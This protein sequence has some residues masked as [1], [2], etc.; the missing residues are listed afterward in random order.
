MILLH[1][2]IISTLI[3]SQNRPL[4]NLMIFLTVKF[5]WNLNEGGRVPVREQGSGCP[6]PPPFFKSSIQE[7][8]VILA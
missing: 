3:F 4:R 2:K 7:A 1:S 5:V 6:A 8:A